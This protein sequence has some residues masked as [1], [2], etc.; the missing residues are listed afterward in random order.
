MT[1]QYWSIITNDISKISVNNTRSRLIS[2]RDPHV[3]FYIIWCLYHFSK[4]NLVEIM[5]I[6]IKFALSL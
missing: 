6:K 1:N 3:L 2:Q 4:K 5:S